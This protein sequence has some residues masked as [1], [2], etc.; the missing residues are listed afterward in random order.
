MS[1]L[2]LN[3]TKANARVKY[4]PDDNGVWIPRSVTV[5]DR[6]T[7]V[8]EGVQ[9]SKKWDSGYFAE[10]E[11]PDDVVS[12]M[13][14]EN[15]RKSYGR[16]V[17][18]L[19]DILMATPQFDTFVTL[20]LDNNVVKRDDY[21]DAVKRLGVW[22]DNRVRR[23]GLTYVLVP[24]FHKD[25]SNVHFHGLMTWDSLCTVRAINQKA[26]SR[27]F[28]H[29]LKDNKG[30]PVFN[31]DDYRLGFST[32]IRITGENGREACAKYCFKYITKTNGE[33]VGGRYYLSGGNLGRP[34]YQ[35]LDIPLKEIDAPLHETTYTKFKR[36]NFDADTIPECIRRF[37]SSDNIH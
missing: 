28:G 35:L 11:L 9:L 29:P 20:T 23:N 12:E 2:P 21:K 4:C 25:K 24:E 31:I 33:K 18:N 34:K 26:E 13:S 1:N 15:A 10:E 27:Y 5:F 36:L 14:S 17:N 19:F 8:P 16:A 22:L 32:A 30:R 3:G 6:P 37:Y 7:Y